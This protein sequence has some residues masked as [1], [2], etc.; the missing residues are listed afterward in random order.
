MQSETKKYVPQISPQP[1]FIVVSFKDCL[2][3]PQV[4]L[5]ASNNAGEPKELLK[6]DYGYFLVY[7][8][9]YFEENVAAFLQ[10][11]LESTIHL[12]GSEEVSI[13][14]NT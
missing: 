8:T 1:L 14:R 11:Y 13:C 7:R 9:G 12:V 4:Q 2:I 3:D 6:F 10:R 5:D